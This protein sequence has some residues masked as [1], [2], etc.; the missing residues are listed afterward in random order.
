VR[1]TSLD[2]YDMGGNVRQW[3]NFNKQICVIRC[4]SWRSDTRYDLIASKRDI[5]ILDRDNDIGFRC[6]IALESSR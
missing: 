5:T 2:L 3:Y 6:I 1:L 4:A